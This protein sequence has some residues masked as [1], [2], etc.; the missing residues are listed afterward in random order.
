MVGCPPPCIR[1]SSPLEG[2][3]P[4][5]SLTSSPLPLTATYKI[6]VRVNK[7]IY[8]AP[9]PPPSFCLGF[10][11]ASSLF[12]VL[13]LCL[14]TLPVLTGAFLCGSCAS[15]ASPELRHDGQG[16]RI[17]AGGSV[18]PAVAAGMCHVRATHCSGSAKG[19]LLQH[20]KTRHFTNPTF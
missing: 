7:A 15:R 6:S 17:L 19:P 5:C 10:D 1:G 12:K 3:F 8:R 2:V 18:T 14:S 4:H 11:L 9:S 16:Q 13:R 20:T